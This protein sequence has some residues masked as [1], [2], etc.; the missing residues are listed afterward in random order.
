MPEISLPGDSDR[1]AI[2]GRTGSGKTQ[3]GAW[4]LSKRSWG[5]DAG[6][7]RKPWF[8]FDT[9]GEGIFAELHAMGAIVVD[10]NAAPPKEP[11]LYIVR[12]RPIIDD[13]AFDLFLWRCWQ[14]GGVG[15]FFDEGYMVPSGMSGKKHAAFATIL[16]QGRSLEM[17]II[18]N[19]QRPAWM[20][21]FVWT[22]S[23]F[24][25]VFALS[26]S[27]DVQTVRKFIPKIPRE[28]SLPQFFSYYFD[29]GTD[30]L[31]RFSPVPDREEIL[32]RFKARMPKR[33]K[34]L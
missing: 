14:R 21:R 33:I 3:A 32:T 15:L 26:H 8:V 20:S 19:S 17:P 25:Q 22:E 30:A 29:V 9:K 31:T 7:D 34:K 10:V 13:D 2:L 24:F 16:T 23:G 28:F 27:D 1:L 6:P 18:V 4:H 5:E 11:G 12:P